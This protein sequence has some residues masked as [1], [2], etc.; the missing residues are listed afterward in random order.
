MVTIFTSVYNRTKIIDKLYESLTEQ[1]NKKE[2]VKVAKQ[3]DKNKKKK[4]KKENKFVQSVR[5]LFSEIKKI[6]WPTFKT[7]VKQTGIV[8]AVVAVGGVVA[9]IVIK[10]KKS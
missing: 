1:T 5:A 10:K 3:N 6:T 2:Q 7:V 8:I 4:E 9:F